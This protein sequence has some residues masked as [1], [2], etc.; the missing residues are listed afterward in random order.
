M[1]TNDTSLLFRELDQALGYEV[2]C[3]ASPPEGIPSITL[4]SP[5]WRETSKLRRKLLTADTIDLAIAVRK[6]D[7]EVPIEKFVDA[8]Q[9]MED[10]AI[11]AIYLCAKHIS[12]TRDDGSVRKFT[13]DDAAY[14]HDKQS[15]RRDNGVV[16]VE[17]WKLCRLGEIRSTTTAD[18]DEAFTNSMLDKYGFDA[19]GADGVDRTESHGAANGAAP[20]SAAEISDES[21]EALINRPTTSP[22]N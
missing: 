2:T 18:E 5:P 7:K 16:W 4:K 13:M 22:G 19:G 21:N 20:A 10:V 11:E 1:T 15:E 12:H 8:K 9:A 17:A 3:P 6:G 14:F